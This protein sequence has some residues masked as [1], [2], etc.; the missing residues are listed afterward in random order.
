MYF[1]F[2]IKLQLY[3]IFY[4][5]LPKLNN[6][7]HFKASIFV[8]VCVCVSNKLSSVLNKLKAKIT[9]SEFQRGMF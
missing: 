3:T 2:T 1:E 6:I 9:N 5:W 7:L 8:C 4:Q